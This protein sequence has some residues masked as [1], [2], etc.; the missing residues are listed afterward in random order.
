MGRFSRAEI[1][2]AFERYREAMN[3]S[4]VDGDWSMWIDEVMT[5]DFRFVGRGVPPLVVNGRDEAH[6]VFGPTMALPG[7]RDFG[8]FPIP[9]VAINEDDAIVVFEIVN[10]AVNVGDG[11]D[12]N[13]RTWTKLHYAGGGQFDYEEDLCHPAELAA[14]VESVEAARATAGAAWPASPWKAARLE[15]R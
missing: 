3:R 14:Y 11:V 6:E 8:S 9:W 7:H 1:E 10:R 4:V 15:T 2:A 12:R 5:K 13:Y